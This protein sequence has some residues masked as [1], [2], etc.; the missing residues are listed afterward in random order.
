LVKSRSIRRPRTQAGF[1]LTEAMTS[2]LIM[3]VGLLGVA[4][5]QSRSLAESFAAVARSQAA[6]AAS[7][8]AARVRANPVDYAAVQPADHACRDVHFA[9]THQAR[10]CSALELAADDL[11]DWR[12]NIAATLPAGAGT[13][14]RVDDR[15][16]VEVSWDERNGESA[17]ARRQRAI[18]VLQP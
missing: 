16:V 11:A 5:L 1:T 8:I 9:H 12:A 4:A 13:I 2:V 18:T 7:D 6:V 15:Y 3:S 17:A 14:R 10:D